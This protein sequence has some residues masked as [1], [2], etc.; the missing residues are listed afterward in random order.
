MMRTAL[1]LLMTASMAMA[2]VP[3]AYLAPQWRLIDLNGERVGPQVT[4]DLS[5]P[6]QVAGQAPCNRYSGPYTGDLPEFR[7]GPLRVTRMACPELALERAFLEA[8]E[9]VTRAETERDRLILTGEGV[10]L[11]FIRPMN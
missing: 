7:P 9:R 10:R 11:E 8:L 4:I 6:G 1:A 2:D 3:P 5:R